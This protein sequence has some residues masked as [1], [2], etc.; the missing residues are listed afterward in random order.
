MQPSPHPN[1]HHRSAFSFILLV[2]LPPPTAGARVTTLRAVGRPASSES[3]GAR[4]CEGVRCYCYCCCLCT[5]A[6]VCTSP[7][8]LQIRWRRMER[9][10]EQSSQVQAQAG[11]PRAPPPAEV[12]CGSDSG[13]WGCAAPIKGWREGAE[14]D[15]PNLDLG[16]ISIPSLSVLSDALRENLK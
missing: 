11:E 15:L 13:L 10:V 9:R 8:V 12:Q 2:P 1:D 5:A 6:R 7:G 3:D 14:E 4:R 16:S